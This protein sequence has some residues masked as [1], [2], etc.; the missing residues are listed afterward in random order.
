MPQ[1]LEWWGNRQCFKCIL[2]LGPL[3]WT[4]TSGTPCVDFLC[5]SSEGFWDVVSSPAQLSPVEL[6][7]EGCQ[8]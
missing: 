8:V 3:G 2:Y 1:K 5:W 6:Q 4:W 7:Q